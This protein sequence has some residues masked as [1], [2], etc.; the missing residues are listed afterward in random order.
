MQNI[1]SL[2]AVGSSDIDGLTAFPGPDTGLYIW[3]I[4][5][6]PLPTPVH[7]NQ[8][9][10]PLYSDYSAAAAPEVF[11][12]TIIDWHLNVPAGVAEG[13]YKGTIVITIFD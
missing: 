4:L 5:G 6:V 8:S 10:G 12:Y 1:H 3:G 11:E 7:G 9:A 2:A 13:T